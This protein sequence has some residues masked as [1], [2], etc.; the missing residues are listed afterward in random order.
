MEPDFSWR[1]TVA[2]ETGMRWDVSNLDV[3][4]EKLFYPYKGHK[5]IEIESRKIRKSLFL[6]LFMTLMDKA[7]NNLL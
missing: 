3:V 4:W 5:K 2:E 6:E 1:C 7:I